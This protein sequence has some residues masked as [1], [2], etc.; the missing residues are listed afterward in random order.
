MFTESEGCIWE[1]E[2]YDATTTNI[3]VPSDYS[4]ADLCYYTNSSQTLTTDDAY[5][6]AAYRLFETL[7]NNMDHRLDVVLI[8]DN[9][10]FRPSFISDI[11]WLWGPIVTT[12]SIGD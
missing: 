11:P 3:T 6:D 12:L 2:F 1:V 4:G 9:I 5:I 8:S 7:D 10:N